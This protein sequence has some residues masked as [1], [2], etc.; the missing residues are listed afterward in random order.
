MKEKFKNIL[1]IAGIWLG[2]ISLVSI[3]Y[4]CFDYN[5]IYTTKDFNV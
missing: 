5:S 2:I 4:N 1:K 3:I